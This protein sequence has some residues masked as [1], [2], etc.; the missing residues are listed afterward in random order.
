[1][2]QTVMVLRNNELPFASLSQNEGPLLPFARLQVKKR[3]LYKDNNTVTDDFPPGKMPFR[4]IEIGFFV[5]FSR[6]QGKHDRDRR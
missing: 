4:D 5:R 6:H 3:K 1:M 2:K